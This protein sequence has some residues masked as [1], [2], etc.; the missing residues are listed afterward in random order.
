MYFRWGAEWF[1]ARMF[2]D[3]DPFD[4]HQFQT[5]ANVAYLAPNCREDG[6]EQC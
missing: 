1:V 6:E 4:F 2:Q 5:V 3:N